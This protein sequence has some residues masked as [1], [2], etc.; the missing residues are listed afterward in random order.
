M[1]LLKI[2]EIYFGQPLVIP[3]P[4]TDFGYLDHFKEVFTLEIRQRVQEHV[5]EL[6]LQAGLEPEAVVVSC[7]GGET[8]AASLEA[9][10]EKKLAVASESKVDHN[11]DEELWG[12]WGDDSNEANI[13]ARDREALQ[14]QINAIVANMSFLFDQGELTEADIAS[15]QAKIAALRCKKNELQAAQEAANTPVYYATPLSGLETDDLENNPL[16][17]L[18]TWD[19]V[20]TVGRLALYSVAAL[21]ATGIR[22]DEKSLE[23]IRMFGKG[24][25]IMKACIGIIKFAIHNPFA[26]PLPLAPDN[27]P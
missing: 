5:G 6:V 13:I 21:K 27:K 15:M 8:D 18:P 9:V 2:P 10:D 7:F 26:T 20:D 1:S 17:Y 23:Q 16:T 19:G 3:R 22:L 11:G 4:D 14:A 25:D 24:N 12:H